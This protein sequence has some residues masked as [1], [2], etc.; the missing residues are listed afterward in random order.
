MRWLSAYRFRG[1]GFS[2]GTPPPSLLRARVD[3]IRQIR[4][5]YTPPPPYISPLPS[6]PSTPTLALHSRGKQGYVSHGRRERNGS[7]KP[8]GFFFYPSSVNSSC[9]DRWET[10]SEMKGRKRVPLIFNNLCRE[11]DDKRSAMQLT[12]ALFI[13]LDL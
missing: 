5:D 11:N 1:G 12:V 9:D 4:H 3:K 6:R 10:A 2:P 13:S 8:D 7:K